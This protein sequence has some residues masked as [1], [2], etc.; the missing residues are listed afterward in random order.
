[1]SPQAPN[2]TTAQTA[3]PPA[4]GPPAAPTAQPPFPSP[5]AAQP[6]APD[7]GWGWVIVVSSFLALLLGYGSSQS[8]GVLYPEWL[9]AYGEGKAMTAWVGSAVA[10]VGLIVGPVC[11]VCVVNFGVRPVTIFSGVMVAGGFMLSAFAPNVPFLIFSYGIVVGVGLG[12][13]YAAVVIITCLYFDKKRGLALGIVSTGTG[14]GGALFA[15]LQSELIEVFGLEG[16]LLIIG[17][18]A[19]NVVPCGGLMRPLTAPR[20]YLK[21]RAAILEQHLQEEVKEKEEELSNQEPSAKDPVVVMETKEPLVR[22]RSFFSFSTFVKKMKH[23]SQCLSSML[24]LLQDRVL[25]AFCV[26]FLLF[27]L[28]SFPPQMFM[29]DLARS[30]GLSKG[31]TSISLVSLNS[32]AT[33]VGKLGLGVIADMSCVNSVLLYALTVA[34]SGL[35]VLLIPFA[36]SYMELQ[37]LMAVLGFS[38]GNWTLTPY[39]T[40]KVVGVEKLPEAHG[41]LMFFGGVGITLG[42]PVVGSFYDFSQSYD[43]AF[44][45]SGGCMMA[46][47]LLLFLTAILPQKETPPLPPPETELIN[48]T[49]TMATDATSTVT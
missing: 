19:L 7:G 31:V 30:S 10:G 15:T 32:I 25:M 35:G 22:R 8:V 14:V 34:V 21:Q 16:C 13:L 2:P 11:S 38:I 9:L 33:G 44:Y 1:M 17:A 26:T 43:L 37:V 29:E 3:Q 40:S 47:S 45:L 36:S 20:Y 39:V 46:G 18:L 24:S 5:P 12:L 27:C 4:P 48:C 41:I 6:P 42:P 28:G 49:V 23:Y